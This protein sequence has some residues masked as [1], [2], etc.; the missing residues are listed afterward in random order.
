MGPWLISHGNRKRREEWGGWQHA[1]MGPWLISH[2][3]DTD[4]SG[5]NKLIG[6]QWGR[7]LLAT[8]TTLCLLFLFPYLCFNGAVAY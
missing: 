6:L 4:D 3:N 7:G 8:E 1:S 2:G 5:T